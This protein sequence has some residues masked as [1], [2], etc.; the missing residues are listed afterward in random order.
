MKANQDGTVKVGDALHTLRFSEVAQRGADG[1]V[2][3]QVMVTMTFNRSRDGAGEVTRQFSLE[4]GT[5]EEVIAMGDLIGRPA[6][7][8]IRSGPGEKYTVTQKG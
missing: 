1:I 2:R 7:T 5:E 8:E 3:R 6:V 4:L